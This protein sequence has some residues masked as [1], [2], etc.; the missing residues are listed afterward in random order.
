MSFEDKE[1]SKTTSTAQD[2]EERFLICPIC[3]GINPAGSKFCEHCWGAAL[4]QD[5]AYTKEELVQVLEERDRYHKKRRRIRMGIFGSVGVVI[6]VLAAL[7]VVNYTDVIAKPEADLNSNPLPGDWSMY[8][9]DLAHTAS[10]GTNTVIPQGKLKWSF[11]TDAAIHSS[12]AVENG[13]VF[14]GSQDH[15]FYALNQDTG[16]LEWKVETGSRK[17]I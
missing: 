10:Y 14:I 8:R 5:K 3:D 2:K 15:N 6:V 17:G 16:D 11:T 12:P 9:Y 7:F 4:N 1:T 13:K